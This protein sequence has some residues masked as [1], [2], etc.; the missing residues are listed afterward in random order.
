[1]LLLDKMKRSDA[2]RSRLSDKQKADR[3]AGSTKLSVDRS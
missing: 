2:T 1:M 3:L